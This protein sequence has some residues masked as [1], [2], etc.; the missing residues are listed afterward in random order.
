MVVFCSAQSRITITSAFARLSARNAHNHA[1]VH[2]EALSN[3]RWMSPWLHHRQS[4][5]DA[6][7][8]CPIFCSFSNHL[9]PCSR[10]RRRCPSNRDHS[11]TPAVSSPSCR[12]VA[13]VTASPLAS[14]DLAYVTSG[15]TSC[16]GNR[17]LLSLQSLRLVS[18]M[19]RKQMPKGRETANGQ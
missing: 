5:T 6:M 8:H 1:R 19:P 3:Y 2:T 15:G 17:G 12:L 10:N 7:Q 16:G 9:H 4:V 14:P 11:A 13:S 18:S